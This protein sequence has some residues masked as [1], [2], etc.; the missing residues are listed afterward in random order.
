MEAF[1]KDPA[2]YEAEITKR[3]LEALHDDV[4][5][6]DITT[7]A[8]FDSDKDSSASVVVKN[9]CVL[10]GVLEAKT[11]FEDGG[12]VVKKKRSEGEELKGGEEVMRIEGSVKEILKRERTALNYLQRMSSIATKS[13]ELSKK[14][15]KR[16][17]FLRKCDP[18]LL[19]S[20]KRAV[21]IGGCMTHRMNLSDGYLIKDNHLVALNGEVDNVVSGAIRKAKEKNAN[22]IEIEVGN[23]DNA[24]VAA[25]TLNDLGICGAVMLDNMPVDKVK[26]AVDGIRDINKKILIEASGGIHEGN[27]QNYLDA[28]VDF[29]STSLFITNAPKVDISLEMLS[30]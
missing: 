3:A 7:N 4:T 9:P 28:G 13:R 24:V 16:I 14:F 21:K 25:K 29:V 11:I 19:Y 27:I 30:E 17:S 15:G 12:L 5:D 1:D 26:D 8:L 6:G 23:E 20:E 10:A 2:I 22:F 18:G